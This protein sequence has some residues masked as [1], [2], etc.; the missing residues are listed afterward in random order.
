MKHGKTELDWMI[1]NGKVIVDADSDGDEVYWKKTSKERES[2]AFHKKAK[3]IRKG[4]SNDDTITEMGHGFANDFDMTVRRRDRRSTGDLGKGFGKGRNK[5][6]KPRPLGDNPEE[7][8]DGEESNPDPPPDDPQETVRKEITKMFQLVKK[9]EDYCD[10]LAIRLKGKR[11]AGL[12]LEQAKLLKP[13][14]VKTKKV[15]GDAVATQDIGKSAL[16]AKKEGE[17]YLKELAMLKKFA[18]PHLK[19]SEV[20]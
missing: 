6:K 11:M 14:L 2:S 9:G 20:K 12:C 7:D 13:S 5:T 4:S 10:T 8:P 17:A 16:R 18:A 19:S 3:L 1:D 15:L